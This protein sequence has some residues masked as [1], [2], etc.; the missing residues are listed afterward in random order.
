MEI[1]FTTI[2]GIVVSLGA[3]L[4]VIV[5]GLLYVLGLWKKGKNGEDDRLIQILQDTVN[6]LEE[7]VN[8]QK[9]EYDETADEL[10]NKIDKLIRKVDHLEKENLTLREILQGR[11]EKTQLFYKKAF[12]SMEIGV[13]TLVLVENMNKN[14][15]ELMKIL[16]EHLKINPQK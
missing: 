12:E 14:H 4:A 7:K 5:A 3:I 13:K 6:A 2:P 11:D 10:T 8:N 16:V 1:F 9:V 15:T